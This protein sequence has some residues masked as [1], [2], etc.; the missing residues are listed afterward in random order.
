MWPFLDESNLV[1][2]VWFCNMCNIFELHS[3]IKFIMCFMAQKER[4]VWFCE[5]S[6]RNWFLIYVVVMCSGY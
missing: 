6:T 5:D 2:L 1:D 4:D 3:L